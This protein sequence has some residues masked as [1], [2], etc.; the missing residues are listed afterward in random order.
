WSEVAAMGVSLALA[1]VLL[2]TTDQEWI[3][4]ASMAGASTFAAIAVTFV[5]PR[6]APEALAKFYRRVEP[7]GF[8]SRTATALGHD[9]AEPRRRL[10]AA[11]TAT[12]ITATSL[13]LLLVGVGK[14]LLGAHDG[15]VG[16]AAMA[17]AGAALVPIWWSRG[18][19]RRWRPEAHEE[20]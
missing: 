13:F 20:A 17:V 2:A 4:L 3:R 9:P 14:L 8:W 12:V 1:P 18:L 7:D 19:V 5:T 10:G 16:A 11:L 15:G 6:T